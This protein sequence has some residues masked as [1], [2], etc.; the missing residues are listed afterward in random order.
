MPNYDRIGYV[1][2]LYLI[3]I[4]SELILVLIC[5]WLIITFVNLLLSHKI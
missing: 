2:L 1:L 4:D 5:G 3:G